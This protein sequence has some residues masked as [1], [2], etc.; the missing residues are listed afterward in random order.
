MLAGNAL[1]ADAA[2]AKNP[3]VTIKTSMGTITAELF[4]DKAPLSTKNFIDYAKAGYFDG[5]IFHRVIGNFMIQ[6]GGMD[7]TL[8]PKP[9]QR[10]PIKN[11]ADNGIK[12]TRGTLAMART[13]APDSATAQWFIN[14]KD[15]GFLDHRGKTPQGYGYAVFGKVTEGMDVVDRIKE[16]P[17]GNRGTHQDVP[18]DDVTIES[19]TIEGVTAKE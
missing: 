3:V 19:V 14:V 15:N 13:S 9:G 8:T 12:N 17:T 6:G 16:V 5:T 18:T 10:R 2:A 11:E 7:A 1:V 4:A